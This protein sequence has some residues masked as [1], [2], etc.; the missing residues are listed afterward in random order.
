MAFLRTPEHQ[1]TI[2][3]ARCQFDGEAGR[4]SSVRHLLH[5]RGHMVD[6][7]K[8]LGAASRNASR[9]TG[10]AEVPCVESVLTVTCHRGMVSS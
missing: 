8:A 4:R 1:L 10:A 2:P 9:L 3:V 6:S 7:P 5:R